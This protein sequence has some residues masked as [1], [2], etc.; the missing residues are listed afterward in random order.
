MENGDVIA[1]QVVRTSYLERFRRECMCL[2]SHF[3]F[4]FVRH[5]WDCLLLEAYLHWFARKKRT[6]VYIRV[7]SL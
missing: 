2:P 4:G 5:I 3:L 7:P 6:I 1:V